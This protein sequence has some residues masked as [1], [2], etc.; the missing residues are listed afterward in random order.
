MKLTPEQHAQA[1]KFAS[2]QGITVSDL[3]RQGLDVALLN[4]KPT[5]KR[6]T[7][8]ADPALVAQLGK[9]GSNLNQLARWANTEKSAV[10]ALQ[11]LAALAGIRSELDKLLP[12]RE[13]GDASPDVSHG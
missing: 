13:V 3:V 8:A 9:I 12:D 4:R 6:Y 2:A 10:D 5:R 7:K 11:V 1:V